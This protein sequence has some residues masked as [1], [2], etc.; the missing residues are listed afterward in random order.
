M[1]ESI[2]NGLTK[3]VCQS[4]LHAMLA[5]KVTQD[6]KHLLEDIKEGRGK[7]FRCSICENELGKR[8][9]LH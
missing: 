9:N 4:S 5:E 1:F 8:K 2:K 3:P 7:K 6:D